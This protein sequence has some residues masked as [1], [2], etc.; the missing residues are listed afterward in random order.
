MRP[1]VAVGDQAGGDSGDH[2]GDRDPGIH[3]GEGASADAGHGGRTVRAHDLRDDPDGVGEV[4]LV[5]DGGQQGTLG[6]IAVPDLPAPGEPEPAGLAD[7]ER[8]EVIVKVEGLLLWSPGDGVHVLD[9]LARAKGGVN[10]GL[11][12][13]PTEEG[14]AVDAR[15]HARLRGNFPQVARPAPVRPLSLVEDR[16]A[17]RLLLEDL[18]AEGH[19]VRVGGV[20][21]PGGGDVG[22]GV[23]LDGVDRGPAG[24]LVAYE[25]CVRQS[26]GGVLAAGGEQVRVRSD[27]GELCLLLGHS[28]GQFALGGEERLDLFVPET[29]GFLEAFLRHEVRA[30]LNHEHVVL[31]A[32][33]DQV[34]SGIEHLLVGRVAEELAVHL[35][36]AHAGD[37]PVPGDVRDH[38]GGGGRVDHEDVRLVDPVHGQGHPDD[39]DLV[40]EALREKRAERAVAEA[41]GEDLLL[42]GPG[43]PL[44]VAAREATGGGELLAVVDREREEVLARPEGLGSAGAA[45]EGG[46]AEGGG[47][48]AVGETGEGARAEGDA[49]G[50]GVDLVFFFH[51][52]SGCRDA[53]VGPARRG[54]TCAFPL[55]AT[56]EDTR[57]RGREEAKEPAAG[58]P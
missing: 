3:E 29:E 39:L 43:F 4:L 22:G 18:E 38:Q 20:L 33:I 13:A 15:E 53:G 10:E 27:A 7:G 6:E 17:V 34:E 25:D 45:E 2:R 55:T 5:G 24:L 9:V 56:G 1:L 47:D 48:G 41:G 50:L 46:L 23:F 37:R 54:P 49:E 8:R 21:A 58:C 44:E 40:H 28:G 11:G 52:V 31:I 42:V 51:A 36:H 35:G 32:H 14:G 26:R 57:N 30:P 16:R 12:L 19:L